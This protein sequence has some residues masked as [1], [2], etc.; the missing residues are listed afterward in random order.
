MN[1]KLSQVVV[2]MITMTSIS[3]QAQNPI[4]GFMN[5][6]G[7]GSIA[8]SH[9]TENYSDVYIGAE[10]VSGIPVFNKIEINSQSVYVTY[11]INDKLDV[12]M[13]LPYITVQGNANQLT[14]D[15]LGFQNQREGLQDVS[16]FVKYNPLSYDLGKSSIKI[17]T[18]IGVKTP[19]G[20]YNVDEGFQ[21]IIAIGNRG[22]IITPVAMLM[23]KSNSG[24][25]V[26]G[27]VGQ[28][29]ASNQ[30]PNSFV[31]ELKTGFGSKYFYLDAYAGSQITNGSYIDILG[32]GFE[33]YFPVTAVNYTK[34]GV[35]L[36]IPIVSGIGVSGGASQLVYGRNIGMAKGFYGG[37]VYQ[38]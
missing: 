8:I 31:S 26:S 14:L 24:F 37:L 22:T 18:A 4:D 27:K 25:F 21:S 20:D 30:V 36:F 34:L 6:K 2:F 29:I 16:F 13:T 12:V 28:N 32:E 1:I 3:S 10:K 5:G 7:K 9:N 35:N 23:Y 19:L 17:I 11:G 15:N 33:G 38:F